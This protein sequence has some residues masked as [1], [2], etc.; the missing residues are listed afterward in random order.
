M[1]D[2][3]LQLVTY[4]LITITFII[5]TL[6][7]MQSIKNSNYKKKLDQFELE[8]NEVIGSPIMV[9]LSKVEVLAKNEAI[10]N[11]VQG[12]HSRFDEIKNGEIVSIND[13]LLE[14]DFLLDSKNY[15]AVARNLAAI[16]MKLYET[17]SRTKHIL[18]EIQEITLSEEKNRQILTNLKASYRT[19]LQSFVNTKSDYGEIANPI[20]LQFETIERRFQDFEIAMEAND[21]DEVSH[22]VR[23]VDEMIKHMQ[24]VID[25]VPSINITTSMIIPNRIN[26]V[27]KTF[28]KMTTDGYQLEFLNVEYN[29]DE[30]NKK[31]SDIKDR[32]RVLNLEDVLL[33]LKTFMTYFDNLFNDFEHE[34]IL[35]KTF[36][37]NTISFKTKIVR[38]NRIVSDFYD[39]LN[40]IKQNYSLSQKELD[41]LDALNDD[42]KELNIDFKAL[43]DTVRTKVFPYSK[44]AKELETLSLKLE[45][46]EEQLESIISSLGSMKDDEARAKEQLSDIN[47][48]MC[49]AKFKMRSYRLPITPNNYFIQLKEAQ[50]SIKEIITELNKK[51]I[52]IEVLNT[53]VDTA[54][55]L[56]LKLFN[57]TNET[58]KT[59]MLAEMAIVYGNRYKS[60]KIKIEEGL[61]KA[62]SLF[63]K[64]DYKRSLE[65]SINSIDIVEP[66][67][68]H[69]LLNLYEGNRK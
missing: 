14:T 22:I 7:I 45:G 69:H 61:N 17:R 62:E 59:A 54:R 1:N 53:R 58:I 21:Y 68:Y 42:L 15:K 30:I 32:V 3:T 6:N 34:K 35:R 41:L 49:K 33:E 43:L 4:F 27:L 18:D 56:V 5:A 46:I 38:L 19:L 50:S 63:M 31:L 23:A 64:G 28:N 16:E 55:D 67:F 65:L 37:E 26:E 48:F 44:L 47:D 60:T 12:W 8:K 20:E 24:V 13:L 9:E 39:Q 11:R 29:I 66:G 57:N 40:I 36:E 25:E 2:I 52:N 10:E 51:P